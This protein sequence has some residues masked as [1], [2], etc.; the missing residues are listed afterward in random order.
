ME[1]Q[2][3]DLNAGGPKTFR[4]GLQILDTLRAAGPDG[5]KIPDIAARTGIHRPTV[6]RFLDVLLDMGYVSECPDD[7]VFAIRPDTFRDTQQQSSRVEQLKPILRRISEECGDS[8]F[9]VRREDA[10]SLCIH[11]EMGGYPVQV[12]SV[13]IGHR[14]PLGVGA[15]G[16]ALLANL[17]EKEIEKAISANADKLSKFGGMTREKL[18]CLV[19][20]T[21]ERGWSVVGN[22]A[23]PGVLGVGIPV[24]RRSGR[25]E[26][27]V[28]VSSLT[29]RMPATRQRMIVETIHRHLSGVL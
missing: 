27:A 26:L 8:S 29:E 13:T 22:A 28:S 16:L 21:Q 20:S 17:S 9:L 7:R 1:L 12:L 10:D 4:R 18:K 19:K 6:Y 15:A 3:Q 24:P 14:Q 5:L 25:P 2:R 23:V 11:R